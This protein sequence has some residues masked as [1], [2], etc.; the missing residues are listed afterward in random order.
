MLSKL[1]GEVRSTPSGL[2]KNGEK[3]MGYSGAV[4]MER[5]ENLVILLLS[6]FF[7]QCTAIASQSRLTQYT[8][9]VLTDRNGLPQN[10]VA[11]ITQTQDGYIWFGTQEGFA[12]FD[13]VQITVFNTL[14]SGGLK[15]N[16]VQLLASGQDG[17]LWIG[18]RSGLARYKDG[19]FRNYLTAKS[20]LLTLFAS[21]AGGVWVGS[22]DG[23]YL[24]TE[25]RVRLFEAKDGLPCNG[26]HGM[27]ETLD[28]TMWFATAKGLV[29]LR[30]STFRLYTKADGLPQIN[31]LKIAASHDGSLWLATPDGLAR[32]NP[33]QGLLETLRTAGMPSHAHVSSLL[34]DHQ[35]TL[36]ITFM[37]DGIASFSKGLLTGYTHRDGLPSD[38]VSALFEDREGHLWIGLAEGG[39]VELR[40]GL[41]ES[42]GEKEGL[43]ENMVVS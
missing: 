40:K 29:S 20:P 41:F 38:D 22:E 21:R 39:A 42:I 18:T 28:G 1:D 36:W 3:A 13:G 17:S 10:P 32:W 14:N 7:L 43:S 2:S 27:A 33:R 26:I 24:V 5:A 4:R 15:D 6:L 8:Q 35:G 16:Y 19:V 11:S 25:D 30:D 34:E 12:R 37:H 23:L 9:T 31:I